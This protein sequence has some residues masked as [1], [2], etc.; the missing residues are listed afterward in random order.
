MTM[1]Y[2]DASE[3]IDQMREAEIDALYPDASEVEALES[4]TEGGH[5]HE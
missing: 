2:I 5:T 1:P 3:I 4:E